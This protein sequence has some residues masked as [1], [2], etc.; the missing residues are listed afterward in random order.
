[1]TVTELIYLSLSKRLQLIADIFETE[2]ESENVGFIRRGENRSTQRKPSQSKKGTNIKPRWV[3]LGVFGGV[4]R[5]VLQIL[6]LFL[7]RSLKSIPI[8]RP[9]P[10]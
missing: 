8:L 3:L 7:T 5:L 1:M 10:S 4:C 6:T 2:L 9:G